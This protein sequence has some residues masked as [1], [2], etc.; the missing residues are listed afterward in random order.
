M[1]A[2]KIKRFQKY[3]YSKLGWFYNFLKKGLKSEKV[4]FLSFYISFSTSDK[5]FNFCGFIVVNKIV[6]ITATKNKIL[7]FFWKIHNGSLK[8]PK[9]WFDENFEGYLCYKTVTY[10]NVSTEAEIKN[11]SFCRKVM[12]RSQDI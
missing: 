12:F 2:L 9:N 3:W 1:S 6:Q 7:S 4:A 10:Q 5:L 11:F 8:L